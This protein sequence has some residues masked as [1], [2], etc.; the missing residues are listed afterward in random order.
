M[1]ILLLMLTGKW[2]SCSQILIPSNGIEMK[3]CI[4]ERVLSDTVKSN[5]N[6]LL[7]YEEEQKLILMSATSSVSMFQIQSEDKTPVYL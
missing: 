1:Q 5:S 2:E 4:S 7:M 3:N 6:T